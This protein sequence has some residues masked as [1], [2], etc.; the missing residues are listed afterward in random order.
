[1]K[2]NLGEKKL[3]F[4]YLIQN[5]KYITKDRFGAFNKK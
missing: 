2:L 1:M 5:Y 4:M 3:Q